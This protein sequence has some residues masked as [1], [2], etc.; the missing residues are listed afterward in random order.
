[1]IAGQLVQLAAQLPRHA[2]ELHAAAPAEPLCSCNAGLQILVH[3]IH[4]Q[5]A[6]LL[7]NCA[8]LCVILEQR[9]TVLCQ[10]SRFKV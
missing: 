1:M 9:F 3:V 5:N 7:E 2:V 10:H 6:V 4:Q 8:R